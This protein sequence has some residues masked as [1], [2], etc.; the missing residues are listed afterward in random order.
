MNDPRTVTVDTI[1]HGPV[2]VPEPFWCVGRHPAG[3]FRADLAHEGEVELLLADTRHGPVKVASACLYQRPFAEYTTQAVTV[4]VEFD[5]THE[6]D[7]ASLAGLADS[8]VAWSVGPLHDLITR[9]QLLDGE[10]S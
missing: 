4:A 6:F 5:A 1:D 7:S 3:E 10:A 9:L 2:T 8:L